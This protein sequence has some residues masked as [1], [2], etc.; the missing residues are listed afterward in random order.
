MGS[1]LATGILFVVLILSAPRTSFLY[2][3]QGLL[4]ITRSRVRTQWDSWDIALVCQQ[5]NGNIQLVLDLLRFTRL[6]Y[7]CPLSRVRQPGPIDLL[8][9]F[10]GGTP[11]RWHYPRLILSEFWNLNGMRW[12]LAS[13][14]WTDSVSRPENPLAAS[15]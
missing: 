4:F 2:L 13:Q 5:P 7:S 6:F 10:V 12:S 8:P 1:Q 15:I 3:L 14:V 11:R 9:G